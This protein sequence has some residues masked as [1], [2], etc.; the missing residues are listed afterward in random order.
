M[1]HQKLFQHWT[2]EVQ[3]TGNIKPGERDGFRA[4]Y[5]AV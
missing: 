5:A 4:N 2:S 3:E 1:D